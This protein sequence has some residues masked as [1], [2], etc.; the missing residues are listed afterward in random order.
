MLLRHPGMHQRAQQAA[1]GRTDA[2]PGQGGDQPASRHH[3]ADARDRQQA[4]AGQQPD[5][6][7]D[8]G[9]G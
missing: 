7:A 5:A 4:K 8:Q 9:A 2:G 3:W 1:A 6:A